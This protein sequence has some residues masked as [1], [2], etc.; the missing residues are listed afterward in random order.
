MRY[1]ELG[2]LAPPCEVAE[3]MKEYKTISV[4]TN[5]GW[6]AAKGTA[7]TEAIDEALNKMARDGWEL[8]CIQDLQHGAGSGAL[9]CVFCREK[10][11]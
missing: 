2:T 7:N 8:V 6:G 4:A 9:L 10:K 5:Q 3:R 1:L 11:A